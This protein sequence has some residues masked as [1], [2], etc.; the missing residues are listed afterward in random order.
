MGGELRGS[1]HCKGVRYKVIGEL[2]EILACHCGQCRKQTGIHYAA[3][4]VKDS[5]L[6]MESER[7]LVWYDSSKDAKRGFCGTC[8]SALF[9]KGNDSDR[10]SI[11]AG[12]FDDK[13]PVRL[14]RHIFCEEKAE[15]YEITDDLPKYPKSDI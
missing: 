14:G 5:D 8:G 11:L 6:V 10:I 1:C 9:W 2:R 4:G 13:L 12:S 7:T 3:T 15:F